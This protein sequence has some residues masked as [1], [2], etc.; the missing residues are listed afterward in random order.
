MNSE[1]NEVSEWMNKM[2]QMMKQMNETNG[3]E[4]WFI[5]KCSG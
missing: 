4:M 3:M 2:K 1:M 5:Y